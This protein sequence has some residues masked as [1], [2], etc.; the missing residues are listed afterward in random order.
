MNSLCTADD[1]N[2]GAIWHGS[3]LGVGADSASHSVSPV[4]A[5]QPYFLCMLSQTLGTLRF[6][7]I[8]QSFSLA[9]T[10]IKGYPIFIMK[11]TTITHTS[12]LPLGITPQV[13]ID[14]LRGH[15]EIIDLSPLVTERHPIPTPP[16]VSPEEQHYTWWSITER[17]TYLPGDIASGEY[18]HTAG[19]LNLSNGMICHAIAPLGTHVRDH[20]TLQGVDPTIS[21]LTPGSSQRLSIR[22]VSCRRTTT[23]VSTLIDTDVH[24]QG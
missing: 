16:H 2:M 24:H 21:V 4:S 1:N 13:V 19:F 22:V 23:V 15:E 12:P 18:T 8:R 3:G 17:I 5:L 14:F 6:F 20:W 11:L 9:G 10:S 7:I